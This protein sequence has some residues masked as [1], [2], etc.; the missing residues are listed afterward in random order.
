MA[1]ASARWRRVWRQRTGLQSWAP[2]RV[3]PFVAAGVGA[4]VDVGVD[5]DVG[6]PQVD[7][8]DR[9]AE[10]LASCPH[11]RR[12]E[13]AADRHRHHLLRS[14]GSGRV[15]G[16]V[17]RLGAPGDDDLSGGVVV[18]D[19]HV[20]VDAGAG[21]LD[22]VV[23]EAEDGGHR[24]GSLRRGGAHR[25]AAFGDEVEALLERQGPAGHE[26]GVLAEAV[27]CRRGGLDAHAL[28]GVEHDQ[29][30]HEGG[31][32]GVVGGSQLLGVGVEQQP[33]DIASQ[34]RRGFVHEL[35]GRV[36]LPCVAHGR[37]LRALPREGEDDHRWGTTSVRFG[38][39]GVGRDG[40]DGVRP[41]RT[42]VGFIAACHLRRW[43]G[44]QPGCAAWPAADGGDGGDEDHGHRGGGEPP[45]A[46]SSWVGGAGHE[47]GGRD[48]NPQALS[49]S[50]V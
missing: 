28:D 2:S 8:G 37:L 21:D 30:G 35:P 38:R 36:L 26:G 24:A 29:A 7:G 10:P 50:G 43:P 19:P 4:G 3:G 49:G 15:G 1:P 42:V 18:G 45:G 27:P 40:V 47:C 33:G 5:G 22:V 44:R 20:A 34:D 23:V 31:Q 46:R 12:V 25:R 9:L 14:E 6:V 13:G 41:V 32:L 39:G 11:E 17:D 48:S 16:I